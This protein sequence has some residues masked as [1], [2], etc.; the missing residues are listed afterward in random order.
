MLAV[1]VVVSLFP[2]YLAVSAWRSWSDVERIE[3]DHVLAGATGATNYLVV[4]TD[5]RA[6]VD[7][8]VENAG[9]IFGADGE[10]TDTIAIL[11][12]DGEDVRLLAIPR[13]LYVPV[14][15]SNNRINAAFAF[16]GP[17]LLVR[18]VQEQ[19]G[20]G[21]D[22]YLEVD[23]AGFLSLVDALGGVTIDFPHPAHDTNSGLSIPTAG[24]TELDSAGALAYVRSRNY[25]ETID[26]REVR[27]PRSDLGRVERQQR[28]LSAVFAE[29]GAT[30]NP[31]TL[32]AAL[33]GVAANV[34]VDDGLGFRTVLSLGLTLRG[35]EPTTATLPTTRFIT[36]AGADVLLL[37]E[38]AAAPLIAEFA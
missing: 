36:D 26:G 18:T 25:V 22:H 2:L 1:L 19:V 28:F 34:R 8:D 33:R 13:D 7:E 38:A 6:G 32:L 23:F 11:R 37:D 29:L 12:V 31:T 15:G 27:D 30:R 10:R 5:S 35:A 24:P 17:E 16:G 3:L 9:V 14:N 21:I 20:I 4:G